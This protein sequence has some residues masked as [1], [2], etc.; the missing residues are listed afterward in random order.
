M[1][2]R[3]LCSR[4]SL[5]EGGG[6][7][8]GPRG[9]MSDPGL[10]AFLKAANENESECLS[11]YSD[12]I[13]FIDKIDNLFRKF[14]AVELQGDPFA[15]TLFMNAHA[16]FLAAARLAVSGQTPPTFMALRGA[17]ESALYGLIASQSEENRLVWVNRD[18]DLKRSRQLYTA[19][20]ALNLL[21]NDPNLF[22]GASEAYELTVE[23][24][25]H[26]NARSVIEHLR[27]NEPH[28]VSLIYLQAI[29]SAAVVR[30]I[31]AC[32]E[33]GLVILNICPHVF[34]DHKSAMDVHGEACKIR[35]DLNLHLRDK[36]Y[37][38]ESDKPV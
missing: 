8:G 22:A 6:P 7:V 28:G 23:F 15:A 11:E 12:F 30:T 16:S 19:R 2:R 25:A 14:I 9:A 26:P 17:L 24:G 38:R 29:S 34:P 33:T 10:Q 3:S 36:G 20:K 31:V 32:I 4:A 27:L 21:R 13:E 1:R 18:R 35:N 5:A 37:L